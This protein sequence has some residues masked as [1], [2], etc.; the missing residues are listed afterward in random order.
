MCNIEYCILILLLVKSF[1]LLLRNIIDGYNCESDN[2]C[3]SDSKNE[4]DV[5]SIGFDK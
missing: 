2:N 4:F 5:C 3:E 1:L